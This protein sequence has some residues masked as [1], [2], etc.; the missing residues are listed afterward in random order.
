VAVELTYDLVLELRF[1]FTG[2]YPIALMEQIGKQ[3]NEVYSGL[4]QD[5]RRP[6][7]LSGSREFSVAGRNFLVLFASDQRQIDQV[8]D[9]RPLRV[10]DIH[11]L[12]VSE[13]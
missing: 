2:Q 8:S 9:K 13:K 3:K 10:I 5:I 1:L 12:K 4:S 7:M 6:G 11:E